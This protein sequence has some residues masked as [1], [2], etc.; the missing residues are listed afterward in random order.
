LGIAPEA[1]RHP[2]E[3]PPAYELADLATHRVALRVDDAHGHPEPAPS[4]RAGFERDRRR[5]RQEARAD[6][7]PARAVDDRTARAADLLEEPAVRLRE[8]GRGRG[9]Y[10]AARR[11]D[12]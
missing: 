5:R 11:E 6:L 8:L 9:H 12:A 10:R 1:A 7:G 3:R 2:G 4:W